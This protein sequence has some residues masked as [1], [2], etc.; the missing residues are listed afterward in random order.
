[1]KVKSL[2]TLGAAS[3]SGILMTGGTNATPIVA[4]VTAGHRQRNGNRIAIAGVTTLTAMNGEWTIS[5]V[6]ATAA[7]LDGSVGNGA[8]AGTAAV[9]A[10]CDRTP[11]LPGNSAA[12]I[13]GDAGAGALFA[14]TLLLEQADSITAAGFFYTNTSGVATAGF[15]DSLLSGEIAMVAHGAAGG[16]SAVVEVKLGRYMKVRCSAYTTGTAFGHLL[17]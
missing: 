6:G 3:L 2:G 13:V 9:A 10:L 7:T 1:M 15:K 17:A 14:G 4:T 16:G 11:F 5:S 8:Y 12:A